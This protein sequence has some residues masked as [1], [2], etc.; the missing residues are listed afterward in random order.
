MLKKDGSKQRKYL[1][2]IVASVSQGAKAGGT[3]KTAKK[4]QCSSLDWKD[5]GASEGQ[6]E[7]KQYG[8]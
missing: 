4:R 8:I 7:E 5:V 1:R 3:G 2:Q 6:H